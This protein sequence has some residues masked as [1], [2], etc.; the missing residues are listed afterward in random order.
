M[1]F[2]SETHE[3]PDGEVVSSVSE[4][5]AYE[6]L[7]AIFSSRVERLLIRAALVMAVLLAAVQLA[8]LIPAVREAWVRVEK[9]EG[10]P[11]GEGYGKS[12]S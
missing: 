9:L 11:F 10:I 6:E 4:E 2:E 12:A 7:F 1:A 8:L 5:A 3:S